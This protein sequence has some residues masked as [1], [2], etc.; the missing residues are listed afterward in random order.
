MTPINR[1]VWPH[2]L[3]TLIL[4]ALLGCGGPTGPTTVVEDDGIR[5]DLPGSGWYSLGNVSDGSLVMETWVNPDETMM[6]RVASDRE[7]ELLS[8]PRIQGAVVE[9]FMSFVGYPSATSTQPAMLAGQRGVRL[10]AIHPGDDN[11]HVVEYAVTVGF[12]HV[13]IGA[14]AKNSLWSSGGSQA[15]ESILSSIEFTSQR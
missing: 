3:V 1:K 9:R 10:E 8:S 12:R 15:V 7:E 2:C 4:L 14:G 11:Y 5:A 6:F 13:F